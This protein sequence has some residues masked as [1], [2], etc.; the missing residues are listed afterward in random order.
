MLAFIFTSLADRPAAASS[1]Q[2]LLAL[3][4]NAWS[5]VD[6][7]DGITAPAPGEILTHFLRR[8]AMFGKPAAVGMIE[9]MLHVAVASGRSLPLWLPAATAFSPPSIDNRQSALINPTPSPEIRLRMDADTLLFPPAL[10]WLAGATVK[11]RGYHLDDHGGRGWCGC[12]SA[13][14]A[15]LQRIAEVLATI[16]SATR[17]L[18]QL[19]HLQNPAPHPRHRPR[20][21]R[22]RPD[23][24]SRATDPVGRSPCHLAPGPPAGS[25][26]HRIGGIVQQ[27]ICG[28]QDCQRPN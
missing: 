7:N 20:P 28:R 18:R 25:P 24:A 2:R 1:R 11:A 23:M 10:E 16:D 15:A 8:G 12:W 6:S 3:G 26:C 5:V 21:A 9:T 17:P 14:V 4:L 22:L 13:P 27:V 19:P